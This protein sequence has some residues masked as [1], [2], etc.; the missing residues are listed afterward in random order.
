[1]T[2]TKTR[3]ISVDLEVI[4]NDNNIKEKNSNKQKREEMEV[5]DRGVEVILS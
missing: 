5:L 3:K 4:G 1:M 2:G